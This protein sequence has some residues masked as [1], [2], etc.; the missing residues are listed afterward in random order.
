MNAL[1]VGYN[2]IIRR[3]VGVCRLASMNKLRVGYNSI[4]RRLVGVCRLASMNKLRV[5]YNNIMRRLVGV[6]PWDSAKTLF[7]HNHVRCLN[8]NVRA[9]SNSLM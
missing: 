6:P 5:G 9:L 3:L 7:I 8:E 2:N 4:I 1:R